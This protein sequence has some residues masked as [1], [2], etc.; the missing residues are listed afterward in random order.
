VL[1]HPAVELAAAV[2]AP[3][4]IAGELPVLYVTLRAGAVADEA[5]LLAHARDHIH[6][7]PAQPKWI[8][9][10]DVM[11]LTAV[12]K[13]YKP[14]LR[15]RAAERALAPRFAAAFPDGRV[16]FEARET[17]RGLT[18]VFRFDDETTAGELRADVERFMGEFTL[19][20]AVEIDTAAGAPVALA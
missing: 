11:P 6:E 16:R 13:T 14:A 4:E 15:A 20:H 2:G 3:D 12:G 18:I 10:I 17:P 5:E 7:R 9:I 1:S 8:E 19:R